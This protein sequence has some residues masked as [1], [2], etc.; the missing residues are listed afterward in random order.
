M[1]YK[2]EIILLI[3]SLAVSLII[4]ESGLRLFTDFPIYGQGLYSSHHPQLGY[5]LSSNV[6]KAD[7]NGFNNPQAGGKHEIVAL[8]D[9]HT[10]GVQVGWDKAWPYKL[11]SSL[12]KSVYNY[13][14]YGY[15]IFHYLY[16]YKE[17]IKHDPDYV[18][19]GLFP[20]N[21][22][23]KYTCH[24]V[25]PAYYQQLQRSG[26]THADCPVTWQIQ[27]RIVKN[28]LINYTAIFSAL[29]QLRK[30]YLRS[31]ATKN[32]G[33]GQFQLEDTLAEAKYYSDINKATDLSRKIV[34]NNYSASK[35]IFSTINNDLR[36][37][38]I[39]FGVLI[40]PS[41][42]QVIEQWATKSGIKMPDGFNISNQKTLID[43]YIKF[44]KEN[45][46]PA[47]DATPFVVEAFGKSV[48]QNKN[49]YPPW[50]SHPLEEG[51]ASYSEAAV[52]L[53]EAISQN[54]TP[55]TKE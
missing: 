28:F 52:K 9:S 32:W 43:K 6:N 18:L 27:L 26:V 53:I 12:N 39:K 48:K 55:M 40:I 4:I 42:E 50:D 41:K 25:A 8:G 1:K 14:I 37:Q 46:I 33:S 21:D 54:K 13:G 30:I 5:T 45:G 35:L 10:F 20:S 24:R 16:L 47:I 19:L 2:K 34:N 7:S 38:G 29:Y 22:I 23:E 31:T 51:Y 49:L 36:S 15:G 17:A 44:M 11:G 3:S